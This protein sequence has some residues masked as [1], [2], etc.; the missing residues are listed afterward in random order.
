MAAHTAFRYYR[1]ALTLQQVGQGGENQA[2]CRQTASHLCPSATLSQVMASV[3]KRFLGAPAS[4]C[5]S[6]V[7]S[8][9][10]FPPLSWPPRSHPPPLSPFRQPTCLHRFPT[11]PHLR[12][13]MKRPFPWD[14]ASPLSTSAPTVSSRPL[15]DCPAGAGIPRPAP[16]SPAYVP[17]TW[18]L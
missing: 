8:L 11:G 18:P 5:P 17:R 15:R 2:N 7:P 16:S 6:L 10:L 3:Q 12:T 13:T 14:R 9:R 1:E 4:P